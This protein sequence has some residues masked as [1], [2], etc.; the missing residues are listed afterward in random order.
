[1]QEI[2]LVQKKYLQGEVQFEIC[3]EGLGLLRTLKTK[4]VRSLEPS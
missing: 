4:K 1:M 2:P 3:K